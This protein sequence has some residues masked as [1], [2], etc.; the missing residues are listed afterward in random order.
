[1]INYSIDKTYVDDIE[2]ITDNLFKI[3]N[4]TTKDEFIKSPSNELI[5]IIGEYQTETLQR[6]ITRELE[7]L[8]ED[9][10]KEYTEAFRNLYSNDDEK[11]RKDIK[12]ILDTENITTEC[13]NK[14][15]FTYQEK[16]KE[17]QK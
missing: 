17:V 2:N 6:Y 3:T 7:I 12:H 8:G 15:N 5:K 14:E 11:E 1:M 10:Q 9:K 16:M 4:S 13:L